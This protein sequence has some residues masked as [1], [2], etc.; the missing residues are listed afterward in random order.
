MEWYI[1]F[2][3]FVLDFLI[4]DPLFLPHP[5]VFMGKAIEFFEPLFRRVSSNLIVNGA[6]FAIFLIGSTFVLTIGIIYL[7]TSI[8]F[9]AGQIVSIILMFFSLSAK[10][11]YKAAMDVKIALEKSGVES[12]RDKIAMIVG[13]DTKSLDQAG[14]VKAAVETVAENFVD[15]FLSPLFFA[16][17]GGVPCAV[18]YKMINTLDSMV[19]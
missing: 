14:I 17:I 13:R 19:G 10:S 2:F 6:L 3:A 18:A 16:L 15:G 8:S 12:G 7:C 11:L 1:I 4:G 9:L 5:V